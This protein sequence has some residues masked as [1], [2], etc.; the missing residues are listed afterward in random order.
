MTR[1]FRLVRLRCWPSVAVVLSLLPLLCFAQSTGGSP[2]APAPNASPQPQ[3]AAPAPVAS[4][5]V[6]S[7]LVLVDVVVTRNGTPVQGLARSAFQVTDGGTA[8]PIKIFEEH[9]SKETP[10]EI[11]APAL[12]P[13]YYSNFPQYSVES[14]A[15]VLLLDG[16]NTPLADQARARQQMIAYLKNIP[17]GTRV[18]V[19]TL[20]SRLRMVQGFTTDS[21]TISKAVADKENLQSSVGLDRGADGLMTEHENDLSGTEA[22]DDIVDN[23]QQFQ[24]DVQSFQADIREQITLEAMQQLA[25]YLSAVPGRKNLIWF[26]GSFPLEIDPDSTLS[27]P[28]AAMRDYS[29]DVHKT[30]DLLSAARV[31]VYPIDARGLMNNS[32]MSAAND[33]ND[34]NIPSGG[35]KGTGSRGRQSQ[36]SK[37]VAAT[38]QAYAKQLK[39]TEIE[40]ATMQQI[41]ADTG[42]KAFIN[43]NGLKEAVGDAIANG[44]NYYTIGYTPELKED[45][46]YR[47]IKVSVAG[48][49]DL[50]YREGYYADPPQPQPTGASGSASDSLKE[51]LELGAPPSSDILFKVRVIPAD[52]P[53]AKGF[54][55]S[56]GP[57]GGG[58]A[59]LKGPVTR[60]MIDYVVDPRKFTFERTP[61][62]VAHARLQ[63]AV[64]AYDSDGKV[65]NDLNRGVNTNLPPAVYA[66]IMQHGFPMHQE[67]DLPSG[68]VFL[69]VL[70]RDLSSG[71]V[72]ATEVPL[73]IAKK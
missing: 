49:Y 36:A 23:L 28:F 18:A 13:N 8:Q 35:S 66:E 71:S 43:T 1:L 44:S 42:G 69:R 52:D 61:D 34:I 54:T 4:L 14:A 56:P 27:S 24:Q 72:G 9:S 16:L 11:K 6:V 46:S 64:L 17:P 50:S 53:A 25:Q 41:A 55:P 12:G 26:S 33:P 37:Q 19:F 5:Q 45:G 30:D 7:N 15:N 21:G 39:Q 2:S 59:S 29:Q 40:Q 62:G 38:N 31:A 20:A 70:V 10:R 58:A 47:R 65:L 57:A 48:G 63:F 51:A 3:S 68:R 73:T 22:F 67:L 60:Y 32:S